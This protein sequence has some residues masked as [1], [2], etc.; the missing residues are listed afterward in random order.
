M[1][2]LAE[3]SGAASTLLMCDST[4]QLQQCW[5]TGHE[6]NNYSTAF[7]SYKVQGGPR[8][9]FLP[10]DAILAVGEAD[11]ASLQ[12]FSELHDEHGR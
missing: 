10:P 11:S 4:H 2:T 9:P 1:V 6:V 5:N 3:N 12:L 7:I 8:N